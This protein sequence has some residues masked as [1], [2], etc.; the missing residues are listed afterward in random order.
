MEHE[1]A[2]KMGGDA[3]NPTKREE[4][5]GHLP[6]VAMSV[7]EYILRN[8]VYRGIL[9][10]GGPRELIVYPAEKTTGL[11]QGIGFSRCELLGQG[12]RG[13]KRICVSR[14]AV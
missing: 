8:V 10:S 6:A 14:S 13:E 1:A 7:V 9:A 11:Q 3:A 12:R 5:Q 2:L 4:E